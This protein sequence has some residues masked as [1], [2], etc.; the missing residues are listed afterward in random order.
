MMCE[1]VVLNHNRKSELNNKVKS[2]KKSFAAYLRKKKAVLY[3][4]ASTL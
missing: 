4:Q 3:F 1:M 2:Y